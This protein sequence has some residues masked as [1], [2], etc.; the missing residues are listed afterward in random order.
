MNKILAGYKTH[1]T[2][3]ETNQ[4]NAPFIPKGRYYGF[5]VL[6]PSLGSG[7]YIFAKISHNRVLE[8]LDEDNVVSQKAVAVTPHGVVFLSDEDHPVQIP[9]HTGTANQTRFDRV[10]MDFSW[11]P[12]EGQDMP[13]ITLVPGAY[14]VS[15]SYVGNLYMGL[16]PTQV[17]L[18]IIKVPYGAVFTDCVYTPVDPPSF[19][20]NP[21]DSSNFAKLTEN[22]YFEKVQSVRSQFLTS[23]N[24]SSVGNGKSRMV[25][26]ESNFLKLNI[27]GFVT[28]SGSVRDY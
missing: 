25:L 4:I 5:D 1:I 6:A 12:I 16:L 18:G 27:H 28:N 7:G 20:N 2:S 10:V 24:F 21:I 17:V 3:I 19:A 8:Y 14:Q 9:L 15:D 26:A 22:N 13:Y 23:S 11:E